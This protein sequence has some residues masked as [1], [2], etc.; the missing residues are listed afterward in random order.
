MEHPGAAA[1]VARAITDATPAMLSCPNA[2]HC[3]RRSPPGIS[4]ALTR[5][6]RVHSRFW[7]SEK[8]AMQDGQKHPN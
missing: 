3:A 7:I 2:T 5:L 8:H 6:S 4:R 1:W